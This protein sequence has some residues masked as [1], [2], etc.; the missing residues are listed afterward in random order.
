MLFFLSCQI[1]AEVSVL[2]LTVVPSRVF[3]K[4][5]RHFFVGPLALT[6]TPINKEDERGHAKNSLNFS[7]SLCLTI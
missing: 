1:V 3:C 4:L 5:Q 6:F 7:C 2:T